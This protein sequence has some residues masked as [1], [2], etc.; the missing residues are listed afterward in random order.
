M[1]TSDERGWSS[2][3]QPIED[4]ESPFLDAELFAQEAEPDADWQPRVARLVN[5]SPFGH[6]FEQ[7]WT[8][9]DV[10]EMHKAEAFEEELAFDP[11]ILL[12][13]NQETEQY[14]SPNAESPPES[15]WEE[16]RV[17]SYVDQQ[18]HEREI[19]GEEMLEERFDP[20]DVTQD[21]SDALKIKDWRLAVKLAIQAGWRDENELTNLIFSF[22]HPEVPDGKLV[23]KDPKFKQLRGEWIEIRNRVVRLVIQKATEDANLKVSRKCV[24]ERDSQ[25]SG[26]IGKKFKELVEWAASEVDINPGLLAAVLLAEKDQRYVYLDPGEVRSFLSGTDDFF[27]QRRQ[28]RM[29]VPAFSKVRFNEAKNTTNINEN[30]REVTTTPFKSGKDATLATAVYLK[31]GEIKLRKAANKNGV[32]FD[33]LPVETRFALVRIAMNAGHGG[34][35][36]EG[37]LNYYKRTWS[38]TKDKWIRVQVK[39]GVKGGARIGVA[40]RLERVLRGEDIL[41]RQDEPRTYPDTKHKADRNATIIVAQAMHLSDWIFGIPVLA[42]AAQPELETLEDFDDAEFGDEF[43]DEE[44]EDAAEAPYDDIDPELAEEVGGSNPEM[45]YDE[46]NDGIGEAADDEGT[47]DLEHL[48][49]LEFDSPSSFSS[50]TLGFEFDLNFGFEQEVI[51]AKGLVPPTGFKWPSEGLK[52]TDHEWW[53]LKRN[54]TDAFVVTMDA[55]RLEIA[56]VP[57]HIDDDGGFGTVVANVMKFGQELIDAKKTYERGVHVPGVVDAPTTF[58]HPR[59]VVNKP[60]VDAHGDRDQADYKLAAVP[61]VIHRLYGKYPTKTGLWS[62]PQATVTLPLAEF[63]KLVWEIHQTK[64]GLPGEAFTGRDKDRLGLRDDLAWVALKRALADRKKKL[65]TTLSDGTRVTDTDFTRSITSLVTILLMYML[66]SIKKDDRD[67]RR[68]QFAKG[69]LP[70]NVKTPLWQIHKFALKDR[71][72]FVFHELYTDTDK[73]ESLF[74]LASGTTGGNGNRKLFPAYTHWDAERFLGTSPTWQ[75]LIDAVVNEKPIKVTKGNNVEKKGHSKGDEILIAPLSSK[76]DWDKTKPR[77]AVEM[78]RLGF[79]AV[80]FKK[81]P[82]L[83]KRVRELAKKVN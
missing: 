82:G 53:D 23:P 64:G 73:R 52:A 11:A 22:Q 55:V 46:A 80:G 67:Q 3:S 48:G 24:V 1:S 38:K 69:S 43:E 57:F 45:E 37:E 20:K 63:G 76:I 79:D 35:S 33:Q 36:Q 58:E 83:M 68:E 18:E 62:S 65:G 34:I 71:E 77:I 30:Q 40:E 42:A 75:L 13:P 50:P 4:L 51:D 9:S 8:R 39:K 49:I 70:L 12:R 56:T 32:A 81:W 21:V 74:V 41:V 61:L 14:D 5:E 10:S 26:E 16:E 25:F 2:R 17:Y 44:F 6:A 78:R 29:N 60:Y 19:L 66:T 54:F 31:Y 72:K 28:L 47:L 59:T 15:V 7:P 27:A